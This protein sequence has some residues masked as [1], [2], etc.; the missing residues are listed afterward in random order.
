M[1]PS[2]LELRRQAN[3]AKRD[4][5]FKSLEKLAPSIRVKRPS[6][7]STAPRQR[8]K[9]KEKAAPLPTRTSS[10]LKGI[11]AESEV[12]KRKSED[13]L[14]MR[15]DLERLKRRRFEGDVK[16][17]GDNNVFLAPLKVPNE[18]TFDV[19]D[20]DYTDKD[21]KE[22]S[23]RLNDLHV[24]EGVDPNRM[25]P[26]SI[27]SR[28]NLKSAEIKITQERTVSITSNVSSLVS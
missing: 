1:A 27:L 20:I 12:A 16:L 28:A 14:T 13:E 19:K 11:A 5:A 8:P 18:P 7:S 3:L 26:P 9:P 4:A 25:F 15:N 2:A 10:R 22:L 17:E 21:F 24:F 23:E 6:P